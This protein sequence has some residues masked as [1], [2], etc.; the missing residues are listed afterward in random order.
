MDVKQVLTSQR[1]PSNMRQVL[2]KLNRGDG[3]LVS[4]QRYQEV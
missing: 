4:Y 2:Q 3:K 1:L